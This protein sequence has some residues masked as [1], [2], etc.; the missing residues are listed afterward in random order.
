LR[1]LFL[2]VIALALTFLIV[3]NVE[4]EEKTMQFSVFP[5]INPSQTKG[6]N[7]YFDLNMKKGEEKTVY[8]QVKNIKK[9]PT[10]IY[11]E[12]TNA[13][14]TKNGGIYYT[15]D[16]KTEYTYFTDEKFAVKE[17][18]KVQSEVKLNANETKKIPVTIT[19]PKDEG[20]VYIGG[21]LFYNDDVEVE[22]KKN[23]DDV[24]FN[25]NNKY[26]FAMAVVMNIG[27][28]P[29]AKIDFG[30][31]EVEMFPSGTQIFVTMENN[32]PAIAL[33]EN[34]KFEVQDKNGK[35]MFDG[36]LGEIKM[37]PKTGIKYP[38]FWAG[39]EIKEGTYKL[40]WTMDMNGEKVKHE[41]EFEIKKKQIKEYVNKTGKKSEQ[42]VVEESMPWWIWA[43]L[44]F[45]MI[46]S[47]YVGARVR[48][49]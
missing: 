40:V 6:I 15:K 14:T 27:E 24:N 8:I 47:F 35:K 46:S 28:T 18:I 25:I 34:A 3:K 41:G 12:P 11:I 33:G 31:T 5:V 39:N 30:D 20:S 26:A 9:E 16:K 45:A 23:K 43:V 48:K 4:A 21:L 29:K 10:T 38:I 13:L 49:K 22:K 19:A 36:K 32:E 7:S 42:V 17:R 1:K 44:A 2:G 37:A